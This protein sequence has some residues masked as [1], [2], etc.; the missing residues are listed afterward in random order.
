SSESDLRFAYYYFVQNSTSIQGFNE[1]SYFKR[2]LFFWLPSFW[3]FFN[4]KPDDFEYVMYYEYMLG[5]VGSMHPTFFGSIYADGGWFIVPWL[6]Y[7]ASLLLLTVPILKL[8]RGWAFFAIWGL[9][10][11]V[12]MMM[13]RGSLY[14][15]FVILSFGLVFVWLAQNFSSRLFFKWCL[16]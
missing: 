7:S 5:K 10:S 14:G 3:D 9:F 4:I 15:P 2:L 16:K 6:I 8:Y 1:F 13:A 11:Y 12:Y